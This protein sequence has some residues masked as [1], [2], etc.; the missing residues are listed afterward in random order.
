MERRERS[1]SRARASL[2]QPWQ[3]LLSE[4]LDLGDADLTVSVSR[5]QDRALVV[6][7]HRGCRLQL[8]APRGASRDLIDVGLQHLASYYRVVVEAGRLVS[9]LTAPPEPITPASSSAQFTPRRDPEA[10]MQELREQLYRD[11]GAS[12]QQR[13][14]SRSPA[15]S[16]SSPPSQSVDDHWRVP[17]APEVKTENPGVESVFWSRV[18]SGEAVSASGLRP[19]DRPAGDSEAASASGLRPAKLPAARSSNWQPSVTGGRAKL[20]PRPGSAAA[21]AQ[22]KR[23]PISRPSPQPPSVPPPPVPGATRAGSSPASSKPSQAPSKPRNRNSRSWPRDP[24]SAA[25]PPPAR[26]SPK[27]HEGPGRRGWGVVPTGDYPE[28]VLKTPYQRVTTVQSLHHGTE[29]LRTPLVC[30]ELPKVTPGHH[31]T[32]LHTASPRQMAGQYYRRLTAGLVLSATKVSH[33][34]S[35]RDNSLQVLNLNMGPQRKCQKADQSKPGRWLLEQGVDCSLSERWH[36]ILGIASN[37]GPANK[38]RVS[39]K[40]GQVD[41]GRSVQSLL[42]SGGIAL[43]QEWSEPMWRSGV[44]FTAGCDGD[45]GIAGVRPAY[46][47]MATCGDVPL[48]DLG[49]WPIWSASGRVKLGGKDSSHTMGMCFALVDLGSPL[50]ADDAPERYAAPCNFALVG[51]VHVSTKAGRTAHQSAIQVVGW[52]MRHSQSVENWW[53]VDFDELP[54]HARAQIQDWMLEAWKE[55]AADVM[56]AP[57]EQQMRDFW[58][59]YGP[60]IRARFWNDEYEPR[61]PF[62]GEDLGKDEVL[63]STWQVLVE[64]DGHKAEYLWQDSSFSKPEETEDEEKELLTAMHLFLE[65]PKCE[66]G[67]PRWPPAMWKPEEGRSFLGMRSTELVNPFLH[68]PSLVQHQSHIGE[69]CEDLFPSTGIRGRMTMAPVELGGGYALSDGSVVPP[70]WEVLSGDWNGTLGTRPERVLYHAQMHSLGLGTPRMSQRRL[71]NHPLPEDSFALTAHSTTEWLDNAA[72]RVPFMAADSDWD[73]DDTEWRDNQLMAVS[74]NRASHVHVG[75]KN[76]FL[77]FCADLRM[78]DTDGRMTDHS[79]HLFSFCTIHTPWSGRLRWGCEDGHLRWPSWGAI[80]NAAPREEDIQSVEASPWRHLGVTDQPRRSLDFYQPKLGSRE[81]ALRITCYNEVMATHMRNGRLGRA[82]EERVA[83]LKGHFD[84]YHWADWKGFMVEVLAHLPADHPFAV[85]LNQMAGRKS[86]E[87]RD[88]SSG[89]GTV[90]LE[91][92]DEE[93]Q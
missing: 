58:K 22:A 85:R 86:R 39:E 42:G 25:M 8:E 57:V 17:V 35:I 52:A 16:Q 55:E 93:Q 36:D 63:S 79:I 66:Y 38:S 88:L 51:T 6:L 13:S 27:I 30:E 59:L 23:A 37:A 81:A 20:N 43:I 41:M 19:E 74:L 76:E 24:A 50:T 78:V 5:D 12:A 9:G 7:V 89:R 72:V 75:D 82:S 61:F 10:R 65:A 31:G 44:T 73:K 53:P 68:S 77:S 56:E 14:R 33:E 90:S 18:T 80:S 40:G 92:S 60:V 34:D 84:Q 15:V 4:I 32:G 29:S 64:M 11:H 67:S 69:Q 62:D 1:R 21:K 91:D 54:T 28:W 2:P 46:G 83:V 87:N 47:S 26:R 48:K 3:D 71:H 45:C 70:Q 49:P